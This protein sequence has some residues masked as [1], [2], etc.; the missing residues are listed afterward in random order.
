MSNDLSPEVANIRKT[1]YD[2]HSLFLN[3]WSP[4]AFLNKEVPEDILLSVFEAARWAP[5]AGNSQ[6]WKYIIA[7][8]AE[9]RERFLGFI[10]PSNVEW[11]SHAPVIAVVFANQQ[12]ANGN[13]NRWGSFDAGTSWGYLALEAANQGL[14]AHAMGGFDKD[15]AK[16]TLQAPDEYEAMAVIAIGYR[17]DK[18]QLSEKH[19]ERE[20]PSTRR[21]L[22]E[23]LFEGKFGGNLE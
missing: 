21:P 7:R 6:P 23:S 2:V 11:C 16:E 1:E 18:E 22:E 13:A 8:A 10:N 17:G 9:D 19:Q 15:K 5:S 12:N 20:K 14:Y 3:R 4:R